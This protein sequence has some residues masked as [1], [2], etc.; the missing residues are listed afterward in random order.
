MLTKS[1]AESDVLK[2]LEVLEGSTLANP[3]AWYS[4]RLL[5][6]VDD[7]ELVIADPYSHLQAIGADPTFLRR[8]P[9]SLQHGLRVHSIMRR[10]ILCHLVDP[11]LSLKQRQL[12]M[13]RALEMIE[14]CRSR[15]ANVFFGGHAE[16]QSSILDPSL[17]SFVERA[18][19]SAVVAPESRLFASAWAG[20]AVRRG[21]TFPDN[22][23]V[24]VQSQLVVTDATA[25]L[26]LAWLQERLVEIATQVDSLSDG[27]SINYNK[28]RWIYNCVRNALAIRP[29]QVAPPGDTLAQMEK[30]LAAWGNWGIRILRDVAS[31]EGTKLTKSVKPF[32]RLVAQHQEKIRRDKL[33]RDHVSK[34]MK[35]EQQ[36][37]LQREREV[38][39][40]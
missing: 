34:G 26:D 39:K 38:A 6:K 1:F 17:A 35:L 27:I 7:E 2:Y 25:T 13:I 11:D 15:M 37:R 14:I 22:L 40:A 28:R 31:G 4:S 21:A 10:W 18:V 3:V 16:A 32:C 8:M 23:A 36:S 29:S 9:L 19:M 33:T 12:R 5:T 30:R 24:L 20:V